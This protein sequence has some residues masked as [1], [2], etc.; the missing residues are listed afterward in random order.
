[1]PRGSGSKPFGDP[2]F[3]GPCIFPGTFGANPHLFIFTT[4]NLSLSY[5]RI[6]YF[7]RDKFAK[8]TKAISPKPFGYFRE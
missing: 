7:P 1:M 4:P 8:R 3:S 2:D 5:L 6:G